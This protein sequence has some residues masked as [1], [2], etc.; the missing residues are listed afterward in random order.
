MAKNKIDPKITEGLLSRIQNQACSDCYTAKEK[1]ESLN[2]LEDLARRSM[3]LRIRV[4]ILDISEFSDGD[5]ERMFTVEQSRHW[6]DSLLGL[7]T[8]C[9]VAK[10]EVQ[11]N[12]RHDLFI[13]TASKLL[14]VIKEQ[15]VIREKAIKSRK[16]ARSTRARRQKSIVG[17]RVKAFCRI[18]QN[19]GHQYTKACNEA[20][21]SDDIDVKTIKRAVGTKSEID[22]EIERQMHLAR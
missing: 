11:S 7:A 14:E 12:V 1:Q 21:K 10:I 15:L 8:S 6:V 4:E 5:P 20:A 2:E 9:F 13:H 18:Y 16:K 19:N 22:Q 3:A 17:R